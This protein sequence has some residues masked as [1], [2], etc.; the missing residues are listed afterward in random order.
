M[1]IMIYVADDSG[2]DDG[3][4]SPDVSTH[5]QVANQEPAADVPDVVDA[6]IHNPLAAAILHAL[7]YAIELPN[8]WIPI[9]VRG[10]DQPKT[11]ADHIHTLN[12]TRQVIARIGF[13]IT[14]QLRVDGAY[15]CL[16][17]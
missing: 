13:D 12:V 4:A 16:V 11:L 14:T 3:Q 1:L 10:D 15:A 17:R 7:A 8:D 2:D 9:K 6:P 5:E